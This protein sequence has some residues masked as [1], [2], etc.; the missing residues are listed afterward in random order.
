MYLLT[1]VD[2]TYVIGKNS[3]EKCTAFIEGCSSSPSH[4]QIP[5]I[6]DNKVVTQ[7]GS[8][9]FYNCSNLYTL[10]LDEGYKVV[11]S[12]S[13]CQCYNLASVIL[14]RTL[15][16]LMNSAFENCFTLSNITILQNSEL[17]YIGGYAFDQC[18]NLTSF[19]ISSLV[20][21]VGIHTFT[22]I[23]TKF[24]LF[25]YPVYD[26][27]DDTMF[28]DTPD[29]IIYAPLNGANYFGNISTTHVNLQTIYHQTIYS[30]CKCNHNTFKLIITTI[31]IL[32]CK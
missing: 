9:A 3:Q 5:T 32:K 29:V 13:F 20:K 14:P 10:K 27:F 25:Y 18:Y 12:F 31:F 6:I 11:G 1:K 7:V 19:T 15:L 23:K 24:T 4:L 17:N 21:F 30:R 28:K 8:H 26:N 2:G 22:S 16:K